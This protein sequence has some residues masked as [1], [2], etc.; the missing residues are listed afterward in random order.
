MPRP[1]GVHRGVGAEAEGQVKYW[2]PERVELAEN[3][4]KPGVLRALSPRRRLVLQFRFGLGG[5]IEGWPNGTLALDPNR[6]QTLRDI[7]QHLL[8]VTGE[9]VRQIEK[10]ALAE[11]RKKGL[12]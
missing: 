2:P 10:K 7:G 12:L 4:K 11:L 5:P 3:L 9:R 8:G 1:R 6:P